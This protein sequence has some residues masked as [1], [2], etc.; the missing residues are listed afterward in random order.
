MSTLIPR[1]AVT[2]LPDGVMAGSHKR[3]QA[4]SLYDPDNIEVAWLV[5]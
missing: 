2:V 4:F 5:T 1:D 3:K